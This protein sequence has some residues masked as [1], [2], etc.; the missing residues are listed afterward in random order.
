[1]VIIAERSKFR[2]RENWWFKYDLRL[3]YL[4]SLRPT[5]V[6]DLLILLIRISS[7]VADDKRPVGRNN[8]I[9]ICTEIVASHVLRKVNTK[10][11][12][13]FK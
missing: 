7:S 6:D 5:C 11:Y 10:K 3:V 8:N 12:F 13:I 4:K 1:M 2:R 9:D